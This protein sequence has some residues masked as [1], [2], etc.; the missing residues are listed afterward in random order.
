MSRQ[1]PPRTCVQCNIY[2]T[3]AKSGI[4]SECK[5]RSA[6]NPTR[7]CLI[8]GRRT[9]RPAAICRSCDAPK[10]A[11]VTA[12]DDALM[13]GRWLNVRGVLRYI[14]NGEGFD[15]VIEQDRQK[16][17]KASGVKALMDER[18]SPPAWWPRPVSPLPASP[19]VAQA[20]IDAMVEDFDRLDGRMDEEVA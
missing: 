10:G 20:R 2:R 1:R 6:Q 19:L 7:S 3:T 18:Y 9:A 8:C 5:P 12:D 16:H 4:C 13:G 15:W 17:A 14:P 11:D